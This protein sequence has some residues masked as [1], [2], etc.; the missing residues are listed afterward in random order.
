MK[1]AWLGCLFVGGLLYARTQQPETGAMNV[2]SRYTVE[3][4]QLSGAKE[5]NISK[6]LRQEIR[7]LV[8]E[9]LNPGY[10]EELARRI[11]RELHVR[12]VS[13]HVM[14]GDT[15]EHVKVV[16][17]VEGRARSYELSVPKFLYHA[18]Q[19]WSAAVE[20]TAQVGSNRFTAGIVSDGDELAE[21]YAGLTGR[22]ENRRVGTDR[23]RL[24]VEAGSFHQQWN[25]ATRMAAG[26]EIYRTRH[27]VEPTATLVLAAPLTVTLG[28]SFENM[29]PDFPAATGLA[30][31]AAIISLRY[32]RQMEG[33]ELDAGYGLRAATSVLGSD[34]VYAR[35]HAEV[36]Y[37]I[38]RG[39]HMLVDDAAAGTI[40][41]RAPL[42]ERFVL[43][44]SSTLR[45]WNKFD[46]DPLG[47]DRMAHNSLE[48]RYG[49]LQVF[50]DTGAVWN[51]G[52]AAVARHSAGVGIRHSGFS[53]ALAFPLREGRIE[54]IFMVGMNY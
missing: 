16:F 35:H 2:N 18:K 19:G 12:S 44:T 34:Y 43:G 6:G 9:K 10:V 30:A 20:G 32:H 26:R 51:R 1:Y 15:P 40:G 52:G 33:G 50:Y 41:G 22:Y 48:Y 5:S 8:G 17:E 4:V 39:R 46:L 29:E 13:H 42:Y 36:R 14:R 24:R 38:S 54:P 53:A 23:V 47:G 25:R 21:R 49:P 28:A 11:R 7:Q 27:A 3:S 31:N 45:G 37:A